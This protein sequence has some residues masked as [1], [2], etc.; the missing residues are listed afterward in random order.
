MLM[1]IHSV[2]FAYPV[3]MLQ[4]ISTIKCTVLDC[5]VKYYKFYHVDWPSCYNSNYDSVYLNSHCTVPM[6]MPIFPGTGNG[7]YNIHVL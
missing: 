1:A 4:M 7:V 2:I 6:I 3:C 5:M